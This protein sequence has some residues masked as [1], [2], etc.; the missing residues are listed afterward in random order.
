MC[1][2]N[3]PTTTVVYLL[4]TWSLTAACEFVQR[5]MMPGLAAQKPKRR[6]LLSKLCGERSEGGRHGAGGGCALP[7]GGR[8]QRVI[9][10]FQDF[11]KHRLY[12][13]LVWLGGGRARARAMGASE[14]ILT[15][16]EE[17]DEVNETTLTTLLCKHTRIRTIPI[18][19][20]HTLQNSCPCPPKYES[21]T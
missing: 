13:S 21:S 3:G 6:L 10:L 17:D 5:F 2:R 19:R 1:A 9:E 8:E 14:A 18:M 4:Y 20:Y 11:R 7:A 15:T 16:E 12:W